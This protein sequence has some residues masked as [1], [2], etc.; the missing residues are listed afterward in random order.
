MMEARE[1]TQRC[2]RGAGHASDQGR[3]DESLTSR[4]FG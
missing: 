4:I 2:T 3:S 1:D